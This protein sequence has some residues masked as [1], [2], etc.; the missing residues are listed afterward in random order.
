M[1]A[2]APIGLLFMARSENG[3]RYLEYLDRKSIRRV[4]ASHAAAEPNAEWIASLLELRD[5]TP[6]ID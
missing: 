6:E 2:P 3:L 5:V 1:S 4:I